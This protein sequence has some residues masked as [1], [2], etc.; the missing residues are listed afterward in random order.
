MSEDKPM[1]RCGHAA[2]A[3]ENGKPVCAICAGIHDGYNQIGN[4]PN[5]AGRQA[6][7]AYCKRTVPSKTSLAFFEHRPDME[8]DSFYDGCFGW[9]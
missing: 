6:R 7:C 2:N 9:D 4:T 8:Y 3:L 1:M 5:L